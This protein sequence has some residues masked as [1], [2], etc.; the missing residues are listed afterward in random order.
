MPS[1]WDK[2]PFSLDV[3]YFYALSGGLS[4]DTVTASCC[5]GDNL[6]PSDDNAA[7]FSINNPVN[8]V[9]GFPVGLLKPVVTGSGSG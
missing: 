7:R 9:N 5:R 1:Q 8:P 6:Q 4:F 3:D 2:G